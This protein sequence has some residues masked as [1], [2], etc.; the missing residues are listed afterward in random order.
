MDFCVCLSVGLVR[1][2][3]FWGCEAANI[4][5]FSLGILLKTRGSKIFY[6]SQLDGLQ[7][8]V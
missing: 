4:I 1:S 2:R 8:A 7:F 6:S 5:F 3:Y